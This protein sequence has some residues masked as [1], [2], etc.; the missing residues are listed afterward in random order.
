MGWFAQLLAIA[1]KQETITSLWPLLEALIPHV[2][3]SGR[4][5]LGRDAVEEYVRLEV[6]RDPVSSRPVRGG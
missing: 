2:A 5:A 4:R 1:A 6:D 3:R